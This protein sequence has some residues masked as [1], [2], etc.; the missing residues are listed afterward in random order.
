MPILIPPAYVETINGTAA[1]SDTAILDY[2]KNEKTDAKSL[3][4]NYQWEFRP[5]ESQGAEADKLTKLVDFTSSLLNDSRQIDPD[6]ARVINDEF[7][8]LL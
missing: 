4:L 3:S 6:L 1:P 8:T 2:L 7:W 5:Y